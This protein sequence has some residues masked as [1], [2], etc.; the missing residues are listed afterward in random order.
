MP[1]QPISCSCVPGG[2]SGGVFLGEGALIGSNACTIPGVRI[3][4]WATV[5]AGAA[6]M[7][8]L[9]ERGSLVRLGR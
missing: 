5:G 9:P 6:A 4:A 8:D 3:G 1:K 2:I 7:R